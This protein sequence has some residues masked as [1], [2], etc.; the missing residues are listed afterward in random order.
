MPTNRLVERTVSRLNSQK[1]VRLQINA[2]TKEGRKAIQSV[3]LEFFEKESLDKKHVLPIHY[4]IVELVFNALKAN[5]KFV[6]FREE[7]RKELNR[8]EMT[9][10]EDFLQLILNERALREFA[11][12]RILP[13]VLRG[14]VQNV[15]NLEE[16][17]RAGMSKKMSDDQ[18]QLI[19]KFRELIRSINADVLLEIH[20]T[21]DEIRIQVLNN[22]PMLQRDLERIQNSRI[23]HAALHKQGKG[24][25]FFSYDNMDTTES[26]GFGIAMVDQ[27]FYQLG[28]DPFEHMKIEAKNKET[29]ATLIY[30]RSSLSI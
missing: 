21:P 26:A 16:K 19:A 13:D 20:A 30:P 17:Y 7:I 2:L 29:E 23:R 5:I 18:I 10:I 1:A 27:G 6:A 12:T 25:E 28:L 14:E 11:A 3:L 22:V 8:F 4:A 15:F 24:G 9:E